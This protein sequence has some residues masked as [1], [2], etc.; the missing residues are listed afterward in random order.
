MH[1]CYPAAQAAPNAEVFVDPVT[2]ATRESAWVGP[3]AS[4]AEDL[5]LSIQ[6]TGTIPGNPYLG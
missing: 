2:G 6:Y 4:L 5:Y 1:Y 3:G